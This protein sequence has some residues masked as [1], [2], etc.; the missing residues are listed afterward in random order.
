MR[1]L[2]MVWVY[3]PRG[4]AKYGEDVLQPLGRGPARHAEQTGSKAHETES[5]ANGA[6]D[7]GGARR[8]NSS[9]ACPP[10][11][12]AFFSLILLVTG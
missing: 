4:C 7:G 11:V 5:T 3:R 12:S 10:A 8:S 9:A 6:P 1:G 2:R